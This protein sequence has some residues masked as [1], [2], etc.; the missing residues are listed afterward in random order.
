MPLVLDTRLGHRARL[1]DRFLKAGFSGFS[2]HEVVELI[3]TLCIPRRDV[4]QPAKALLKRFGNVKS[5]LEAS[6]EELQ[7]VDGIGEVAPVA[8]RIVKETAN[9][10]LQQTAEER[11]RF[12]STS[13]LED[14]WRS[15]IGALTYEV[16]EVAYLDSSNRLMKD[17]IERMEEGI[18]EKTNVYPKKIMR[19]ALMRNA[20]GIILAHNHPSGRAYPSAV[21]E[22]MTE[23]IAQAGHTVGVK[24]VDHLIVTENEVFS[25]FREDLI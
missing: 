18:A 16:F 4:K 2:E 20:K 17:G 1:R 7:E 13:Q 11:T 15:R 23:I 9:L 12:A 10:Y 6:P 14:F 21:D 5:I 22:T 19:S 25:F 3:L 8:M 24:V